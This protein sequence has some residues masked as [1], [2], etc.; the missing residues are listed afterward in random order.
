MS[1]VQ[2][3]LG[4][5]KKQSLNGCSLCP[6]LTQERLPTAAAATT[7]AAISCLGVHRSMLFEL[8]RAREPSTAPYSLPISILRDSEKRALDPKS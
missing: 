3:A 6:Q 2:E 7:P 1:K 8:D 4:E 5:F